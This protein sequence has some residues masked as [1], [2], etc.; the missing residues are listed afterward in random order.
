M[1][2][3]N[4]LVLHVNNVV[5]TLVSLDTYL[6][7]ILMTP[8]TLRSRQCLSRGFPLFLQ[9]MSRSTHSARGPGLLGMSGA[10]PGLDRGQCH[11]FQSRCSMT[12]WTTSSTHT[13]R[14]AAT[15][16]LSR[17]RIRGAWM[18]AFCKLLYK[19]FYQNNRPCSQRIFRQ[20]VASSL[21]INCV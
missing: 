21:L 10:V 18:H 4:I 7:P 19:C 5:T 9:A 17:C 12:S 8:W 15:S 6:L 2:W 20:K 16:E 14:R 3:T 11:R 13:P 1:F